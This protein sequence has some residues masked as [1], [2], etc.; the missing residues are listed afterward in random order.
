MTDLLPEHE[1]VFEP[2]MKEALRHLDALLPE[3]QKCFLDA[4]GERSHYQYDSVLLGAVEDVLDV[5]A[6]SWG[7]LIAWDSVKR[8]GDDRSWLK[9]KIYVI[10]V[11]SEAAAQRWRNVRNWH[12]EHGSAFAQ[13]AKL[14]RREC[15]WDFAPGRSGTWIVWLKPFELIGEDI[16][17][18]RMGGFLICQDRMERG[19]PPDT[20]AHV[21]VA[22]EFRR[23][24][25]AS[26]LMRK[27]LKQ[28]DIKRIDGPLTEDGEALV[29]ALGLTSLADERRHNV[30]EDA[31]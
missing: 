7:A 8:Y 12:I 20:I 3:H 22:K 31:A 21:W 23:H 16:F 18:G 27:A 26:R 19:G 25:V 13:A 9:P 28:F 2:H 29:E 24:G 15:G 5:Y 10:D 30:R 17:R 11:E 1:P 6:A 4:W 14:Y